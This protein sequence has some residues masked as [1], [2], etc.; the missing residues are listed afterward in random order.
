[1]HTRQYLNPMTAWMRR[2][3]SST[4]TA[5][6]LLS[7]VGAARA[8]DAQDASQLVEK[9]VLT[10]QQFQS[11]SNMDTFRDL[12]KKAHGMLILPQMLRAAFIF[13]A[14]GGSGVMVA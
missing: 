9:A 10:V 8:H 13:G 6:R 12:A 11:D 2:P 7:G 4:L 5:G 3:V 14:S 1:M